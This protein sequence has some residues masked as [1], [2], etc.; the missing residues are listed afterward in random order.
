M[1]PVKSRSYLVK[2][3]LRE[4]IKRYA[5]AE[6]VAIILALIFSNMLMWLWDN[7]ILT[8]FITTWIENFFFYGIITYRDLKEKK[9][10]NNGLKI[11]DFIIQ[12]RNIIIE[13]GPSEYLDSFIIRPFYLSFFPYV[14]SNYTLA[15]FTG[16]MMANITYYIPIILL[17]ELRK[18]VFKE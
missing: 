6:A 2:I 5:L 1:I 9:N 16:I 11:K 3:K 7:I 18:K 17:Y 10:I 8:G 15:I 12:L 13:F 4:W 14:I